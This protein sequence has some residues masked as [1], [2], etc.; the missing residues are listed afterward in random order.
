MTT[1]A[2][3]PPPPGAHIWKKPVTAEMTAWATSILNDSSEYP[4][5]SEATKTFGDDLALA[6]VEWHAWTF[7]NGVKVEGTFRGVT[8]YE[9][10]SGSAAAE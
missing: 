8:L 1:P 9:L 6:R 4:M 3:P 5:F 10:P 2:N 7:R